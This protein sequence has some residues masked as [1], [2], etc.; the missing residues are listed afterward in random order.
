MQVLGLT[1]G[2]WEEGG[3]LL[4]TVSSSWRIACPLAK[5]QLPSNTVTRGGRS[6]IEAG[7]ELEAT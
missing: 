5:D 1:L 4:C 7:T 3:K 6:A 2:H